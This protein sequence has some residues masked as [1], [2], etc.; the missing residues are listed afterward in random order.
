MPNY[1]VYYTTG[2]YGKAWFDADDIEHAERLIAEVEQGEMSFDDLP[3]LM[4]K[5]QGDELALTN[6]TELRD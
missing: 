6:L 5:V 4:T 1:L 3:N 2:D